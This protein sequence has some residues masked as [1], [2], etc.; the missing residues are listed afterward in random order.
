MLL[1]NAG[2][3]CGVRGAG[4]GV[5]G[6]GCGVRGAGCGCGSTNTKKNII[7]IKQPK[8]KGKTKQIAK[9]IQKYNKEDENIK[10]ER[11]LNI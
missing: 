8:Q 10:T 1:E 6:A 9:D 5:L 4:C 3:E 11:E 2:S 7:I